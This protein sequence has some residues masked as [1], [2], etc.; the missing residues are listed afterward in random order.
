MPDGDGM[1]QETQ[2]VR[3]REQGDEWNPLAYYERSRRPKEDISDSYV[4]ANWNDNAEIWSERYDDDGD[5]NRRF[6][7]DEPMLDMLG[8]VDGKRILDVGSGNGYLCRKLTE[9]G[10]S[11]VGVEISNEFLSIAMKRERDE[12]LGITYINGSGSAMGFLPDGHFDKAVSN[13]VL[14]DILDYEDSLEHVYRLLKPGGSFVVVISHPCFATGPASWVKPADDS[15]RRE[16]RYAH[17]VDLYFQ[18]GPYIGQWGRLNPVLSFHRPIRDYWK[19]FKKIGFEIDD[20][21]EPSVSERGLRELPRW[22]AEQAMRIPFS[23]IFRLIKP[24]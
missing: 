15:P 6:Q 20:F 11:A 12:P 3:Y 23:C 17:L 2:L 16:E 19:A 9:S 10:A 18:R 5:H 24:E 22:V 8:D 1:S 21:E 4:R 13:Y 7:S 14:M